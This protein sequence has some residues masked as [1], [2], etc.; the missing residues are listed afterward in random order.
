MPDGVIGSEFMAKNVVSRS[1]NGTASRIEELERRVSD[2]VQE[3]D[4][5][6]S[7]FSCRADEKRTADPRLLDVVQLTN[8]L[9]PGVV[10]LEI[11][12]DPSEPDEKVV[13]LRVESRDSVKQIIQQRNTWH[14]RIAE[15]P[16]GF[17]GQ[18]SLSVVPL[19]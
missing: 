7:Q 10:S 19:E 18:F 9:F 3:L 2:L 16:A 17:S 4:D 14:R 1:K 8:E 12:C 6:K 11:T 13:V 15:I 5:L